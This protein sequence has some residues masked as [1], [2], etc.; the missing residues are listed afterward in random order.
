MFDFDEAKEEIEKNTLLTERAEQLTNLVIDQKKFVF[1]K[2]EVNFDLA[3]LQEKGFVD[4]NGDTIQLTEHDFLSYFAYRA[5][6]RKFNFELSEDIRA[7][8]HFLKAIR[9]HFDSGK[10]TG[11]TRF[12]R[13]VDGIALFLHHRQY[14][15]KVTSF[16]ERPD[17]AEK[18]LI[19]LYT[20]ALGRFLP[21]HEFASADLLSLLKTLYTFHKYDEPGVANF[22]I[23]RLRQGLQQL[24]QIRPEKAQELEALLLDNFD[25]I[26]EDIAI[27]IWTGLIQNN[28][29]FLLKLR[30]YTRKEVFQPAVI[31]VL[32]A[33]SLFNQEEVL[34]VLHLIDVIHNDSKKY[35]L[36]LPKLYGSILVN[37]AV[38]DSQ[39]RQQCFASLNELIKQPDPEYPI[40]VM[41]ELR[42]IEGYEPEKTELLKTLVEQEHFEQKLIPSISWVFFEFHQSSLYFDFLTSFVTKFKFKIDEEIF[43]YTIPSLRNKDEIAFDQHLVTFLIHDLGELRWT[44]SRILSKLIFHHGM[45][46]FANNILDLPPKSQF[47]LFTS[48]LSLINEAKH[49][50]PSV[51][52]LLHSQ[53]EAVREGLTS[54]L[55]ILSEDYGSQVTEALND[56]FPEKTEEQQAVYD[57]IQYYMEVFF[58]NAKRKTEV[59]ELNPLHTQ[60]A[61]FDNYIK[62]YQ[63]HF[64]RTINEGVDK[65]SIMRQLATTVVLAKGGG[66]QHAETGEVMQLSSFG[67]SMTLPRS[68]FVSPDNFE[69]DRMVDRLENWKNFLPGWEVTH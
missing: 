2:N 35:R 7:L 34:E 42:T 28:R 44:G 49:T 21:Y 14:P 47:K 16:S 57:R 32:S 36:Q 15:R 1:K 24:A 40:A 64:E 45:T 54:R 52:P 8:F 46:R 48:V 37:S 29:S 50:L 31:V 61:I 55:E 56:Y 51:L 59:K 41:S 3:P 13:G 4:I 30:D 53:N 9:D 12:L 20:D 38:S 22:N 6:V 18:E 65:N 5:F 58:N 10:N 68:Y 26:S 39:I 17:D 23:F 63:K 43:E 11:I 66:W 60:S 67:T 19:F 62:S 69:W 25:G 33:K 27:N